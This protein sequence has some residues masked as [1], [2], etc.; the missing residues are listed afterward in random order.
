MFSFKSAIE[1]KIFTVRPGGMA[2][3]R[4]VSE[5][6]L[7]G[8]MAAIVASVA[9]CPFELIKCRLQIQRGVILRQ[10]TVR[11]AIIKPVSPLNM[12][13]QILIQ[14]GALTFFTG[15]GAL[16]AREIPYYFVFFGAS[17]L[18]W[19][20]YRANTG[21]SADS[22]PLFHH[23]LAGAAAGSASWASVMPADVLKSRLQTQDPSASLGPVRAVQDI[24]RNRGVRGLYTGGL[25]AVLRALV[26][27]SCSI[28][29]ALVPYTFIVA[30]QWSGA[31][32]V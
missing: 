2:P 29:R 21:T 9:I 1:D 19:E 18:Y 12:V 4:N 28:C 11:G 26:Q 3:S 8:S 13:R 16:T 20:A 15:L 24:I 14:E 6:A 10:G 27:T 17:A 5:Q 30:C 31:A 22:A 7:S 32:G 23:F 25:T